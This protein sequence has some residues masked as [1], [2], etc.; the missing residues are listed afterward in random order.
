MKKLHKLVIAGVAV[1]AVSAST[2]GF[3]AVASKEPA[4]VVRGQYDFSDMVVRRVWFNTNDPVF[5]IDDYDRVWLDPNSNVLAEGD[6]KGI[7]SDGTLMAPM[8]EMFRQIGVDY[9][10]D[11][12]KITITMNGDTLELEI[13]KRDV[14]FNGEKKSNA[15]TDSQVPKKVNA[16]EN[17][18]NPYLED[19]YFVAYLPVAYVLHT[20]QADIYVDSNVQSFYAAVPV[21][22]NELTADLDTVQDGY[23]INYRSILD[24]E[25]EVSAEAVE[26]V[27][28][29]QNADGGFGLLP[30]TVDMEQENLAERR[31]SLALES[32]LEQG[33][34]IAEL[35]YLA[36]CVEETQDGDCEEAL[37]KGIKFLVENQSSIGGWQMNP[38]DPKGFRA[39]VVFT[40]N[41]TTD[42]LRLL[43]RVSSSKALEEVKTAVGAD[44][45]DAAVKHGDA[46]ILSSQL[47]YDGHK[48][49]WA[50]QYS[51][52]GDVVM[53]RTYERESVSAIAT[54]DIAD[55]LMYYC[56]PEG[57]V[58][59]AAESAVNWLQDVKIEDKEAVV[60]KD[61]SMQNG[62]DV[63]LL[64]GTEPGIVDTSFADDG[65]G[66][67]AANYVYKA[68]EFKP[69]Y[70]DVDPDRPAQPKV[71]DWNA[72]SS[73]NLIWYATR[74]S[75]VYY[76]N[77]LADEL[78]DDKYPLWIETGKALG[79]E[80]T[81]GPEPD[82]EPTPD[83]DPTPDPEP[84][85]DPDPAPD[86]TP[87]PD[88]KPSHDGGSSDSSYSSSSVGKVQNDGKWVQD[89]KGW[90]FTL[91]N[92]TQPK[93]Q[94]MYLNWNGVMSWYYFDAEGYMITGW[95]EQDGSRYYLHPVSDGTMGH[96]YVGW[97][98][99]DGKW[100]YFNPVSDGTRG[101]L[102][103]GTT[104]PDGYAVGAD[105]AWIQ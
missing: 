42:V 18:L 40:D 99:I 94:W 30:A 35:N 24:G 52:E 3:H 57:E 12:D 93:G 77:E 14:V 21:F 66:T 53:G 10:E 84:T 8:A 36:D 16:K 55:Y 47:S 101:K 102:F 62:Y 50:A 7:G 4:N 82:P 26:N 46:F 44:K 29:V 59:E 54:A 39:N 58:K 83:P 79:W 6:Y 48:S 65:L 61:L 73:D 37:V 27:L 15:L 2:V 72:T 38:A 13:G 87:T 56:D 41:I 63:F 31:G 92:G 76:D 69:L 51:T 25:A 103:V 75:I 64:D 34:T 19:D 89:E 85:P 100:Y 32:T 11:G 70:A 105:G 67:W 90:K 78:I 60:I 74:S 88:D 98:L 97:H 81:P 28:A 49:G 68:G 1:A 71:N 17:G 91:N 20:F 45:I 104:T 23:G 95:F 86:P 33:A 80:E 9:R 22:K 5:L 96:M 43:R